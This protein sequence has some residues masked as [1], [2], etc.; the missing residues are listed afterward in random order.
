MQGVGSC[1]GKRVKSALAKLRA[2]EADRRKDW[3]EK[4][5]TGLARR[6]DLFRVENL[7]VQDMTRSAA[8]TV[9][10]PG[11]NVRQKAGLNRDILANGWGLLV[12][13]FEE[14]A[15]GRVERVSPAFTSQRCS[16]CGAVD[17]QSRE[18]PSD[19]AC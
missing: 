13:R 11:R 12:S 9:E 7:K 15:P 6:F 3:A 5:T 4:P 1:R 14:K 2:H 18:S 10:Q 16:A 8:G 17:A 19:F